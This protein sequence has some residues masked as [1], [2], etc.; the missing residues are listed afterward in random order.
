MSPYPPSPQSGPTAN[1]AASRMRPAS[2]RH[3]LSR[4]TFPNF[5]RLTDD[6]QREKLAHGW[7]DVPDVANAP[8]LLTTCP[9]VSFVAMLKLL[10]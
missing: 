2:L 8:A 10:V 6:V 9:Y 3:L 5:S 7:A 4:A 1:E